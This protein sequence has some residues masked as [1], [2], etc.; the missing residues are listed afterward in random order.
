MTALLITGDPG[1]GKSALLA[2]VVTLTT[3]A[4]R[5]Q[6][7]RAG[8]L[9]DVPAETLPPVGSVAC[10]VWARAKTVETLL[11]EVHEGLFG[12]RT[13]EVANPGAL[14]AA[15]LRQLDAPP[16]ALDALDEAVD[17]DA[18]ADVLAELWRDG[19]ARLLISS[20]RRV[21][22]ALEALAPI[23]ID[24]D[25]PEFMDVD[26]LLA[27]VARILSERSPDANRASCLDLA[28]AIERRARGSFLFARILAE[29]VA[30]EADVPDRAAL[31]LP[32]TLGMAIDDDLGRRLAPRSPPY[33]ELEPRARAARL[34]N[35]DEASRMASELLR[36][37]AYGRGDGLPLA[38][39]WAAVATAI[40]GRPYGGAEIEAQLAQLRPYLVETPQATGSP[41]FRLYHDLL[42]AHFRAG[43]GGDTEVEHRITRA[44]LDLLPVGP[45]GRADWIHQ[46]PTAA[47]SYARAHVAAH[48]GAAGL[49]DG[50]LSDP[51]YLVAAD[52]DGLLPQLNAATSV[53][54]RAAAHVYRRTAQKLPRVPV[55]PQT[56]GVPAAYLEL[57]ARQEGYDQL[58]A[59]LAD[60]PLA[61][62]WH[63]PFAGW[64][65]SSPGPVVGR[66][67]QVLSVGSA[68]LPDGTLLAVT[69]GQG[70]AVRVW[71]LRT[72][73]QRHLLHGHA[74]Q[75]LG[76]GC[77]ALPDGTPI[78]FTAGAD[79]TVR[80]WDLHTGE[81]LSELSGHA[82]PARAITCVVLADGTPVA[83]TGGD[84]GA[85]RMWD[86]QTRQPA[87]V[88]GGHASQVNAVAT[89]ELLGRSIALT[90]SDD[91]T[92]RV[93]DLATAQQVGQPLERP[94]RP[95]EC[96]GRP[97]ARRERRRGHRLVGHDG[98]GVGR[99]HRRTGPT[100]GGPH[101]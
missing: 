7:K 26:D 16:V 12:E 68:V 20:R 27:Y 73:E 56:A 95:R 86:I 54:A 38:E 29:S 51:V 13:G 99:R 90:G 96:G 21:P 97:R 63:T 74:G 72:G 15:R 44:L 82:G 39:V 75:V 46:P 66:V 87:H 84:D 58:A 4:Y 101:G 30:L 10:A 24:L 64:Q 49:L 93:W 28:L 52:P 98:A 83:V 6:A 57:H 94:R 31:D 22:Y 50:L 1:S 81:L 18:V 5:E 69:G 23:V 3:A 14:L 34:D 55:T 91:G 41:S 85:V 33:H 40:S 25:A 35:L 8:A 92:V 17:P 11:G 88:L 78:A 59:T 60:A 77:G 45:A 89:S 42:V 48:A 2:R 61:Q 76:V 100:A 32:A 43:R 62:P 65:R 71:D 53:G 36:P 37:L 19:L 70:G 80:V 47:L 67:D 79:R 9:R